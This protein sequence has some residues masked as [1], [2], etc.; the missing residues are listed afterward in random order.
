MKSPTQYKKV[1]VRTYQYER[2]STTIETY[3]FRNTTVFDAQMDMVSSGKFKETPWY[4]LV[5]K[6]NQMYI[7]SDDEF[8]EWSEE[9]LYINKNN[10]KQIW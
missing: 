8:P 7:I 4:K 5:S 1:F 2:G 10:F 3:T 9:W 6:R